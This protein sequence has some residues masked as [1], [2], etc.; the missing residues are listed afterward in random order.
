MLTTLYYDEINVPSQVRIKAEKLCL[1]H[2][3]SPLSMTSDA[4]MFTFED[5][6]ALMSNP[7]FQIYIECS[8]DSLF[9]PSLEDGSLVPVHGWLK[10][11]PSETKLRTTKEYYD[12]PS[13][14]VE[15]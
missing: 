3:F 14:G 11:I 4:Q 7:M 13:G 12:E 5:V 2:T 1:D 6:I 10:L 9:V 8:N 15:E